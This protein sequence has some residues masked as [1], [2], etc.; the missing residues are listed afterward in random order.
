MYS[1]IIF[2]GVTLLL[3]AA[4]VVFPNLREVSTLNL[5]G[6]AKRRRRSRSLPSPSKRDVAKQRQREVRQKYLYYY[7]HS[8]ISNQLLGL[9]RAAQLCFSTNRILILP[10]VLP[11]YGEFPEEFLSFHGRTAGGGCNPYEQSA[12]FIVAARYDAVLCKRNQYNYPKFSEIINISELSRLM[13]VTMIELGDFIKYKPRLA[14]KHFIRR[15]TRD[16][17]I[18]LDGSCTVN[19]RR[20]YSEM[21]DFFEA[22]FSNDTV[23]IIPSAFVVRN[24]NSESTKFGSS[25]AA[26]PPSPKLGRVLQFIR[27]H[28]PPRYIG[29]HVRSPD[30]HQFNCSSETMLPLLSEIQK[31]AASITAMNESRSGSGI[32]GNKSKTQNVFLAGNSRK[33]LE[34]F[35]RILREAGFNTFVL[36][37][38]F[39]RNTQSHV[40]ETIKV[41]RGVLSALLDQIIVSR[42][43]RIVTRSE[44]GVSTF[45][46]L[47][48]MRHQNANGA[49]R[50]MQHGSS[51]LVDSEGGSG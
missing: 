3:V 19:Y 12:T 42:G 24:T 14:S 10:P 23:A 41:E 48:K 40:F 28:L 25:V 43:Q 2:A 34:C 46:G 30:H 45:Q 11:H 21:I 18:D 26:F 49:D 1:R 37:D 38:F 9:A 8:G 7:S 17:L 29:V 39:V 5:A 6:T 35:K 4:I 13:N 16:Q 50:S 44:L 15:R 20:S 31:E 27:E 36:D 51:H 32:Q 33:A 22:N 47:I